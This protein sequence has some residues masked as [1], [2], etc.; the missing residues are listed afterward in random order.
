MKPNLLYGLRRI[1]TEKG[2]TTA[3]MAKK[4]YVEVT[5]YRKWERCEQAPGTRDDVRKLQVLL[6]VSLQT[7]MAK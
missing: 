6:G 1:R 5:T 4:L 3:F 2:Y 7:L